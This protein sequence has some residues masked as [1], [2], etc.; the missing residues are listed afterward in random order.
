MCARWIAFIPQR[1]AGFLRQQLY[2][3]LTSALTVALAAKPGAAIFP[4]DE[5]PEKWK[6]FI[7]I[8]YDYW[9]SSQLN[10]HLTDEM[11]GRMIRVAA[12]EWS[13]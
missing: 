4:E 7:Q 3:N 5:V 11:Y 12:R 8:N 10:H 2:I 13:R 1:R 6:S 9:K